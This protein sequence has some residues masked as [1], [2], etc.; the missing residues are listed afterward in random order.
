ME[1][2]IIAVSGRK[3]SGKSSL[4]NY[5]Q[6]AV[7]L[8]SKIA[9]TRIPGC[10]PR[11]TW[12][13]QKPSGEI[14]WHDESDREVNEWKH[15]DTEH[16]INAKVYNFADALK[17]LCTDILGIKPEQVWGTEEQKN[18]ETQF[19]WDKLPLE[20][21][22]TNSTLVHEVCGVESMFC[23]TVHNCKCFKT[24]KEN[25]KSSDKRVPRSGPM[26]AR[27]VLQVMGTEI[28]RKMFYEEV[29]IDA[30]LRKIAKENPP[31]ALIGDMR[32]KGEFNAIHKAGGYVIRL[33]RSVYA[34]D[35]HAS[36]V[37]FDGFDFKQYPRTLVIP[38][39]A[40]LKTKNQMAI[41]WLAGHNIIDASGLMPE[42]PLPL[43]E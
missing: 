5:I 33:E 32:F 6:A 10:N 41:S 2:K 29:W 23:D 30:T 39:D 40:D 27:Q 13:E 4:C 11:N 20:I 28:M 8:V 37:D 17:N 26:T 21:R 9:Y 35:T 16:F 42:L 38:A 31:V 7:E 15:T 12:I 36:E 18:S 43:A 14:V 25:Q 34:E 24:L 1:T 19:V 22:L 3:F